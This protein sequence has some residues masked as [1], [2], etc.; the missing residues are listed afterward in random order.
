VKLDVGTAV[1]I[2]DEA[3]PSTVILKSISAPSFAILLV[4]ALR[5]K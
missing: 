4:K 1:P 5:A 2:V 3:T